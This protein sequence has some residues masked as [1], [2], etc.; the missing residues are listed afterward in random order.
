VLVR[1][2]VTSTE[3]VIPRA[4]VDPVI[5]VSTFKRAEPV[6]PTDPEIAVPIK[7]TGRVADDPVIDNPI[8]PVIDFPVSPTIVEPVTDKPTVDPV[9]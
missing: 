2:P 8:E 7:L 3:P 4:R 6:I 5:C 1:E 9:S